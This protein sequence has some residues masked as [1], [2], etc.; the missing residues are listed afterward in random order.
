MEK[1]LKFISI[2][3]IGFAA[4]AALMILLPD[5]ATPQD[6]PPEIG[7]LPPMNIYQR[8]GHPKMESALCQLV[9]TYFTKGIEKAREFAKQKGISF[10]GD[11][12]RVVAEAKSLK[13]GDK[14]D[15][16]F[17]GRNSKLGKI[18]GQRDD[19][20]SD[21]LH[22]MRRQVEAFGGRVETTHRRL[23]QSVVP[24][25]ALQEVADLSSVKY[26][27]LPRKAIPFVISEGV[28]KTDADEW[29]TIISYRSTENVKVCILDLGFQGHE[30]LLGTEL[31]S[32]VVTKSFRADGDLY[33]TA[34]GTA[35]AEIVHDMAPDAE[36]W[37]VNFGTDVEYH[38]AVN[39]IINQGMDDE[40]QKVD[41]IS[42]SVGW[43]NSGA[44]DGTGLICADVK[45]AYDNDI[46][47]VSAA[48]NEAERHWEGAFRDPDSD[49]WCNFEEPAQAED[50]WFTFYAV[51]GTTYQVAL[52]WDDWG[53][54]MGS[55][56]S[57]S[58]GNDYDLFLYDSG[59]LIIASSNNDQ[60]AGA[61]PEEVIIDTALSSGWRH[62]RIYK[63]YAPRDCK[64]ELFFWGGSDLEY[65]EPAGSLAIPADSPFAIAVGATDWSDDSYH[66]YSSRGP[67]EDGRIKPDLVA[68]SGVSSATY[69]DLGFSG[70]SASAPHVAGAFALLMGK[71]PYTAEEIRSIIEARALDLGSNGKDNIFGLGRLKLSK[72][73]EEEVELIQNETNVNKSGLMINRTNEVIVPEDEPR[74]SS[75]LKRRPVSSQQRKSSGWIYLQQG[76]KEKAL[77]EFLKAIEL[78]PWVFELYYEVGKI[79]SERG[80]KKKAISYLE[81]YFIFGGREK[82]AKELLE[83]LKKKQA[84]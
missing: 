19:L 2:L 53:T 41:I 37:L 80:E 18:R 68:P 69:G 82:A 67:T 78:E 64:L 77:E 48:G 44:G 35:C 76:F 71:L 83:S 24:L 23:L 38:N 9:E 70:T 34:H 25:Y 12:V 15:T 31:P 51:A 54:W 29:Q 42:C 43:L 17:Y 73:T 55:D 33:T 40:D 65:S 21:L 3:R 63:W 61:K 84:K 45:N 1:N 46:I 11:L 22:S 49:D 75:V 26:L 47:W 4:L 58:E 72:V 27:R 59:G 81:K 79:Y 56:Y 74:K 6:N 20:Q 32:S 30:A 39:W 36:L 13:T 52:N 10:Q 16:A 14:T 5:S 57:Y 60:T 66:S 7:V 28:E 50:E 62:I 8:E